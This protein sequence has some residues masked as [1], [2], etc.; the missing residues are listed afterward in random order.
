MEGRCEIS[1]ELKTRKYEL[2]LAEAARMKGW[3]TTIYSVEIGCRGF[4]SSSMINL[5]KDLGF[6]GK[7]RRFI[8]KKLCNVEEECS[9]VYNYGSALN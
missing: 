9:T 7:Q 2:N 8:V 4:A 5:I 1:T 3:K 6:P